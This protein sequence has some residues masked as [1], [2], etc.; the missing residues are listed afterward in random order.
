MIK[1]YSKIGNYVFDYLFAGLLI[2]ISTILIVPFYGIYVGLIAF[3]KEDSNYKTIFKTIKEN[4]KNILLMSV[5]LTMLLGLVYLTIVIDSSGFSN[6]FNIVV[7]YLLIGIIVYLLIYPPIIIIEMK[8]SFKE[9]IKNSLYLSLV[10]FKRTLFMFIITAILI[11]LVTVEPLT[12]LLFVP[13]IQTISY[14][15]N[16]S[17]EEVKSHKGD[18]EV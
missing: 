1:W 14:L 10:T 7:R 16:K 8:V 6:N 9:L 5:L 11:W 13:F 15:T 12:I 4:F 18:D 2:L 3:F 17:I